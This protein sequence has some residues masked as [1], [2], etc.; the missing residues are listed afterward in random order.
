MRFSFSLATVLVA[1]LGFNI[2]SASPADAQVVISEIYA[3]G[4]LNVAGT[5]YNQDYI[6]LF[7]NGNT[8]VNLTGY[9]LQYA[10]AAGTFD[11]IQALM[12]SIAPRSFFL[13]QTGTPGSTGGG[14]PVTPDQTGGT[15]SMSNTAGKVAL[16]NDTTAV[17]F[18]ASAPFTFSANVLDFVGYGTTATAYEGAG[19][20]PAPATT[21]RTIS[22][23]PTGS[24]ATLIY[25]DTNGN[26]ADFTSG[27]PNLASG[28]VIPEANT[29]GLIALALPA[30][31]A[32]I[33]RRR[34]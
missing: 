34:R 15:L 18:S 13:L 28:V 9:S 10:V 25:T 19:R 20:A 2:I 11:S 27:A 16:A 14:A 3:A 5:P 6:E 29:F 23:A 7:N 8:T 22:R 1:V 24:G 12:G 31:G 33:A 30:I 32:A 4:G 21:A 17:T 26:S